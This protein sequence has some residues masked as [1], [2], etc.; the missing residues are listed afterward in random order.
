MGFGI[1]VVG[2]FEPEGEG[3]EGV[4]SVGWEEVAHY[5]NF[6]I[7]ASFASS[8]VKRDLA[9]CQLLFANCL[10]FSTSMVNNAT[11]LTA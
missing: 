2:Y 6:R 5:R 10:C 7:V 4:E 9:N 1:L 11:F 3:R 8:A